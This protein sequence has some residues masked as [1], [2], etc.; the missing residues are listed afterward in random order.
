MNI[1]YKSILSTNHFTKILLI[2]V[3]LLPF[4]HYQISIQL[5][6]TKRNVKYRLFKVAIDT[7]LSQGVDTITLFSVIN[8]YKTHF[9]EKY[10]KFN[11]PTKSRL[12]EKNFE[13]SIATKKILNFIKN[14]SNIFDSE[15]RIYNVPREII[16]IILWVESR[17]GAN[18]G[19]HHIPSVLLSIASGFQFHQFSKDSLIQPFYD[20]S[21]YKFNDFQTFAR[22][23]FMFAINELKALIRIKKEERINVENLFGSFSGAFG[24]PQFLPSSYLN[25]GVDGDGDGKVDLF[26][27]NDAIF[28]VANFLKK[29]G[30]KNNDTNSFYKSIFAYNRSSIYVT[31]ILNVYNKIKREKIK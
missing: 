30:W 15:E 8:D 14:Y 22:N 27:M 18:T 3:V 20:S 13:S 10:V 4:V 21:K 24:I 28:S 2:V 12:E 1:D 11:I 7:L 19:N 31:G 25:Y 16:A 17:F 9:S 26:N 6:G 23:K 5:N 29:N